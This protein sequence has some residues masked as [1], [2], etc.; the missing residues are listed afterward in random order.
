MYGFFTV[1]LH[2][3]CFHSS[4][5]L[6]YNFLW[7]FGLQ[8][9]NI[10]LYILCLDYDKLNKLKLC[11]IFSA[12]VFASSEDREDGFVA[13]HLKET[14]CQIANVINLRS[15]REKRNAYHLTVVSYINQLKDFYY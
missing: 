6:N 3:E 15:H 11:H 14:E 12:K 13:I 1:K 4:Y 5:Y 10:S 7:S 9:L 8:L 2:V